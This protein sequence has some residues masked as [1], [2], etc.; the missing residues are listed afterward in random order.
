MKLSLFLTAGMI[1]LG[2]SRFF[3]RTNSMK[4]LTGL[5]KPTSIFRPK[6]WLNKPPTLTRTGTKTS[7]TKPSLTRPS[8]LN[9]NSAAGAAVQSGRSGRYIDRAMM[10]AMGVGSVGA[11]GTTIYQIKAQEALAQ[12]QMDHQ[13]AENKKQRKHD[14]KLLEDANKHQNT[15]TTIEQT[16]TD[17]ET[18][19]CASC[20]GQLAEFQIEFHTLSLAICKE[21]YDQLMAEAAGMEGRSKDM[22]EKNAKSIYDPIEDWCVAGGIEFEELVERTKEKLV[23]QFGGCDWKCGTDNEFH[24]LMKR[25]TCHPYEYDI[26][27]Y[28]DL[29][30]EIACN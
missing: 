5:S 12:K 11:I 18:K 24:Q 6:S 22:M 14:K 19:L 25:G 4:P 3:G 8:S 10:G 16:A 7:V 17:E 27:D 28:R 20:S 21:E 9:S 30:Q 15:M 13:T 2:E 26:V 29:H 1:P 23:S